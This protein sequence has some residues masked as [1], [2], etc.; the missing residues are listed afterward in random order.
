MKRFIQKPT[1]PRLPEVGRN[2]FQYKQHLCQTTLIS[3]K[4]PYSVSTERKPR[5]QPHKAQNKACNQ[6]ER[7]RMSNIPQT[8]ESR[9]KHPKIGKLKA[10][11]FLVNSC[12][13]SPL[14]HGTCINWN[15]PAM[16]KRNR[17]ISRQPDSKPNTLRAKL[18]LFLFLYSSFFVFIPYRFNKL[19]YHTS[20]RLFPQLPPCQ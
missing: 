4:N 17:G 1:F 6:L 15:E 14:W 10:L 9:L 18:I 2:Q 3:V 7:K 13:F 8:C 19:T 5:T 12:R 20:C 11:K 16:Q